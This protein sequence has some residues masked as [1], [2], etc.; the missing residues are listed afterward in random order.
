MKG[1]GPSGSRHVLA[2]DV[3]VT[4]PLQDLNDVARRKV[5]AIN[6]TDAESKPRQGQEENVCR[7]SAED[8]IIRVVCGSVLLT[9]RMMLCL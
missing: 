9:R 1:F 5:V 2:A 6:A 8:T 3:L 7:L 4:A